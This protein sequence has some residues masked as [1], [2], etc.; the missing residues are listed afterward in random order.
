MRTIKTMYYVSDCT[1][2]H[3][4]SGSDDPEEQGVHLCSSCYRDA[5]NTGQVQWLETLKGSNAL[6]YVCAVCEY[7]DDGWDDDD[8]DGEDELWQSILGV[9]FSED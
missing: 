5:K 3:A 6:D 8:E 1:P 2:E 9:V 7:T 4:I